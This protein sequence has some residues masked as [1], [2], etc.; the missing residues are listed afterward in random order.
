MSPAITIPTVVPMATAAGVD[1]F[2]V[3]SLSFFLEPA[4]LNEMISDTEGAAWLRGIHVR[5][6]IS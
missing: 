2:T 3:A 4:L 5:K 1:I 6:I